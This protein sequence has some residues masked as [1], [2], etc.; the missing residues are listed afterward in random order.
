M[1]AAE[2]ANLVSY[3]RH[4][5]KE[6]FRTKSESALHD[7]KKWEKKVDRCVEVILLE[8]DNTLFEK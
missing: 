1:T 5:Q 2:L 8:R 4:F 7:A 3:M 6:Y